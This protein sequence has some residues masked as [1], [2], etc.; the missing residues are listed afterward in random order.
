MQIPWGGLARRR[1]RSR[2]QRRNGSGLLLLLNIIAIVLISKGMPG[3]ALWPV[4][5]LPLS[6]SID[7]LFAATAFYTI[8]L[9]GEY[10][11]QGKTKQGLLS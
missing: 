7:C 11:Y 3:H 4:V 6:I 1:L 10:A 8:A 2:N 5:G 9:I